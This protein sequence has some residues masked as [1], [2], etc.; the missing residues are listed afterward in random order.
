M[1]PGPRRRTSAAMCRSMPLSWP[2][3]LYLNLVRHQHAPGERAVHL[4]E[5]A[6]GVGEE[7]L[8]ATRAGEIR[9]AI[10]HDLQ[11]EH[12]EG[13]VREIGGQALQEDLVRGLVALEQGGGQAAG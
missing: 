1:S 6:H 11:T 3:V 7:L 2:S 9:L 5:L 8:R 12:A 13:R 4:H 10:G